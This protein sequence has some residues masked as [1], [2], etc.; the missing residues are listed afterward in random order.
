MHIDM[1]YMTDVS[2]FTTLLIC[3]LSLLLS[4]FIEHA[5]PRLT[6]YLFFL[7]T[8]HL[9]SFLIFDISRFG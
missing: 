2:F 9:V 7:R 5:S 1:S 4:S 6:M 8:A 3:L